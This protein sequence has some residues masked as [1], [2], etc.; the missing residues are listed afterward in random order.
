MHLIAHVLERNIACRRY[1]VEVQLIH[2]SMRL[3]AQGRELAHGPL[4]H[5][6]PIPCR[7]LTRH[8]ETVLPA[9]DDRRV[10]T[11]GGVFGH[12][13]PAHE[14]AA[15]ILGHESLGSVKVES[16]VPQAERPQLITPAD[17]ARKGHV[18]RLVHVAVLPVAAKKALR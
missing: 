13:H 9:L 17:V 5:N 12:A 4:E 10:V 18:A 14:D 7:E 6:A 15:A 16:G 1:H 2:S 3:P 11:V 8:R